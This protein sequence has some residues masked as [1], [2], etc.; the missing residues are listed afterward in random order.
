MSKIAVA[1]FAALVSIAVAQQQPEQMCAN[2]V[3]AGY[4]KP[5]CDAR[6]KPGK[7]DI[8]VNLQNMRPSDPFINFNVRTWTG[9]KDGNG[10]P[11]GFTTAELLARYKGYVLPNDDMYYG[12]PRFE[13]W[14]PSSATHCA[15]IC[16]LKD[17]CHGFSFKLGTCWVMGSTPILQT[18]IGWTSYVKAT[19]STRDTITLENP[20]FL[21][22]SGVAT[23]DALTGSTQCDA[24]AGLKEPCTF[25]QVAGTTSNYESLLGDFD[26]YLMLSTPGAGKWTGAAPSQFE[27]SLVSTANGKTVLGTMY[28]SDPNNFAPPDADCGCEYENYKSSI[29][30]GSSSGYGFF[31]SAFK[32]D[33]GEFLNG[34]WLQ[35]PES[36]INILKV[37]NGVASVSYHCFTDQENQEASADITITGVDITATTTATL[38]YTAEQITWLV[39]GKIVH[40]IA[41]PVC[42]QGM[43][44]R[45]ILS[46]EVGDI[47]PTTTG[48]ASGASMGSMEIDYFR[49]WDTTFVADEPSSYPPMST[50]SAIPFCAIN[51]T[52]FGTPGATSPAWSPPAAYLSEIGAGAN[53]YGGNFGGLYKGPVPPAPAG[54]AWKAECGT[55]QLSQRRLGRVMYNMTISQ[56]GAVCLQTG[57]CA[58]F[59][60]GQR[61]GNAC[62]MFM[63]FLPSFKR[64]T[65]VTQD[66]RGNVLMTLVDSGLSA[67]V[68]DSFGSAHTPFVCPTVDDETG[69]ERN[70]YTAPKAFGTRANVNVNKIGGSTIKSEISVVDFGCPYDR[71]EFV[72]AAG[73]RKASAC[74]TTEQALLDERCIATDASGAVNELCPKKN[75]NFYLP[76]GDITP[77]IWTAR[78]HAARPSYPNG[79]MTPQLCVNMCRDECSCHAASWRSDREQCWLMSRRFNRKYRAYP[80]TGPYLAPLKTTT[81]TTWLKAGAQDIVSLCN[82]TALRE[83]HLMTTTVVPP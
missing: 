15:L 42:L 81:Y 77:A 55:R 75:N 18:S 22:N 62:R 54:K 56:C 53:G 60:W 67:P 52:L 69:F 8:K 40:S 20:S 82:T 45:P 74:F 49:R 17:D 2:N 51:T 47:L 14:D 24:Y 46:I 1:A 83:M 39:N 35:G 50:V 28:D 27:E 29:I 68:F 43:S 70:C 7:R 73:N 26:P 6:V 12:T 11:S 31:E 3:V 16:N 71:T 38:F 23:L 9:L 33:A 37:E 10:N 64:D 80:K 48:L 79:A 30:S 19:A 13:D 34:F 4:S 36:E 32:S 57:G 66:L 58:N 25:D 59:W 78:G 76:R 21:P 5:L 63:D 65:M 41:T 44:M 61:E 72:N